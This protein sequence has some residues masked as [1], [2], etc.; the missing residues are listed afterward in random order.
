[1]DVDAL[2]AMYNARFPVLNRFEETMWFDAKGYKLAGNHRT[3]GQIQQKNS[4]KQFEAYLE[5][6][7]KN[8][9][10]D[11][12][13]PPFYKADRIGEYRQAHAAFTARMKGAAS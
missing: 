3:I 10:P 1:M 11:G 6:P 8:P 2:I 13:T 5:Y 7:G 12:Y 9:P 4:W